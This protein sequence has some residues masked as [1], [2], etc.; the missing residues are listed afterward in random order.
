MVVVFFPFA[1]S[2]VCTGELQELRDRWPGSLPADTALVA[3]SCDPMHSLR[4]FADA[5]RIEIP[6]LSDFWPHGAVASG[7]GVLDDDQGLSPPVHLR[8]RARRPGAVERASAL[9]RGARRRGRTP[10]P[11]G[12]N[13]NS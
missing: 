1:F 11:P 9:G 7:F 8:A 10:T 6:L 5:E 13:V 4:A 12:A 3:V 2:G